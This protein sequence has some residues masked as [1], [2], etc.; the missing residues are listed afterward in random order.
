M[1][2][3]AEKSKKLGRIYSVRGPGPEVGF[4]TGFEEISFF[5]AG[6]FYGKTGE[7]TVFSPEKEVKNHRK[8][9]ISVEREA[10]SLSSLIERKSGLSPTF[11]LISPL[12]FNYNV[13]DVQK[14]AYGL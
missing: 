8:I 7:K 3:Q 9:R 12:P 1:L 2:F 5:S 13:F 6:G 10:L 11:G 14:L 4:S